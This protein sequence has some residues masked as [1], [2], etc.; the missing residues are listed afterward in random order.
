MRPESLHNYLRA[1]RLASG[2]TQRDVARLLGGVDGT[3]PSRYELGRRSPG[4]SAVLAYAAI[5][6]V[7]PRQLFA[8]RYQAAAESVASHAARLLKELRHETACR[9][10]RDQRIEYLVELTR[11]PSTLDA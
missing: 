7:D 4:L 1:R 2:L 10:R 3:T 5:L 6:D 11:Q 8:G 9:V